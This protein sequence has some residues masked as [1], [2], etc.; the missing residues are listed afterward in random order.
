LPIAVDP[1]VLRVLRE[2]RID[3]LG[4]CYDL[5]NIIAI[6]SAVV[7]ALFEIIDLRL[8]IPYAVMHSFDILRATRRAAKLIVEPVLKIVD[9]RIQTA[10]EIADLPLAPTLCIG[11]TG[12]S[13]YDK[14]DR[15]DYRENITKAFHNVSPKPV[16]ITDKYP[17]I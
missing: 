13:E 3:I 7:Q 15:R 1:P 4:R 12:R 2:K 16:G 8:Q 9:L 17:P 11:Q 6:L 14:R 5:A 10:Y